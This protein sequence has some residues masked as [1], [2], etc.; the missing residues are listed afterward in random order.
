MEFTAWQIECAIEMKDLGLPWTPA[1]GHY[2]YDRTGTL[3]R[4][5]PFQDRVYFLLNY[6]CFMQIVGGLE[7]FQE[8]MVWLP[9]W[10]QARSILESVGVDSRE[11]QRRLLES[12]EFLQ[13]DELNVLYRLIHE[14]LSRQATTSAPPGDT[15]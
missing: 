15:I 12:S 13:G 2:V 3:Q 4:S 9:D 8:Q 7:R 6:D 1:V 14:Q 10:S 5:S 11:A